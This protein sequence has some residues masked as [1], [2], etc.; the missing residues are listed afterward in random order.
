LESRLRYLGKE[1]VDGLPEGAWL[2]GLLSIEPQVEVMTPERLSYL[3]HSDSERV[4]NE[5]GLF[6]FDEVHNIG[7]PGRGWTLE[8]DLAFL[9]QATAGSAHKIVLMSAAV[10]NRYHF[11]QWMKQGGK[12]GARSLLGLARPSATSRYLD[13][14]GR[15]D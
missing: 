5:V 12:R 1:I 7:E 8:S 4:L 6:I 3:L 10:G 2:D 11:V 13:D 14:S 15:L 9:H